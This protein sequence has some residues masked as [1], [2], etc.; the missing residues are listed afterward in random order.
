LL[1]CLSRL[2]LALTAGLSG[3]QDTTPRK[4]PSG[5]H[6]PKDELATFR[7][8]KGFRVELVASEPDVIDPVAI[9]FDENGRLFVAEM[10]GY[11]NDG[12]GEGKVSSGRIRL[13]TE[14]D[15]N[16]VYR[17]STVYA[18]GLRFPTSVMPYRGGLLVAVAPDLIYLKDNDDDGKADE[19]RVLY[20]GFGVYNIQ[21]LLNGL[22]WGLDNWVYAL[23]GNNPSTVRSPENKDMPEI[24]LRGRGIRFH[25]D[26][27]GSLDPTSGGGQFGLAT[28]DWQRWFTATNSQHLRH[29]VLPD[30]YL[31]R[32]PYLPVPAVTLDVPDGVDGHGAV[33]KV[34]RISPFEGWRVERT[35][36]RKDSPDSKRFPAT[37]LV[38]GGFI[39]SACSPVVY[40]ADLFP[41]AFLNNTFVCEPANN[42]IHR[43]ILVPKGATFAAKRAEGDSEFLASTD[44]WFRPVNLTVGPDGA[45]YVVDFYREV[46]ETPLSLPPEMKKKLPLH[47]QGKG[48]IWRIVPQGGAKFTKPELSKASA[49]D[50]VK[51]LES[52]NQWWRLTAQ[53]LLVERQDKAA[54]EPLKKLAL[55]SKSPQARAHAHWTLEGLKQLPFGH[56]YDALHDPV[57]EV[58]EQG[59][60][61]AESRMANSENMRAAVIKLA[62][63]AS[64]RVRFQAAFT[65]GATDA[66]EA[67]AALGKLLRRDASEPWTQTAALSSAGRHGP[68]LLESLAADKT[69]IE[70][71][72][73]A[74]VGLLTR[75]ASMIAAK[76]D[77]AEMARALQLLDADKHGIALWQVA[78]LEGL[79]Q[80]QQL[81]GRSL[82]A[83]WE[84]PPAALKDA[85]TR[86]T[87]FFDRAA[88]S[89][90]DAKR[91]LTQRVAAAH[92]LGFG[93]FRNTA[94]LQDLL[95]PSNPSELQRAAVRALASHDQPKVAE[96]L[97][98][99]WNSQGPEVRNDVLEAVFARPGR[100]AFLLTAIEQ[101]KVLAAQLPP[102]RVEQLRLHKD[103]ELRKRATGLLA[104]RATPERQ[105]VIE[106]YRPALDLKADPVK[107]KL[108]FQKVCSTCHRLEKVGQEVGPDLLS[109]LK[110]KTPEALLIDILDPSR[111]VDP[112][113]IN[114]IVSTKDG[115]TRTGIVA[116]EGPS[117]ITLRRANKEEEDVLRSQ[118]EEIQATT[119][120]LMPDELE[121]QFNKQDLADLIGYLRAVAG[122]K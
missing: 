55:E 8:A 1:S 116:V 25:P 109:A 2:L 45:L 95:A 26:V 22:Q 97:L 107:G 33:C 51:L 108:V 9:A 56:V 27:P 50:L 88:A 118:I 93:P 30:Q 74:Q 57:A 102:A 13:L 61:L 48:R 54:V 49:A 94:P 52:P 115:R 31:R 43:D 19:Q 99:Q 103:P 11:P 35:T 29:I 89:A 58:R 6:A 41:E 67:A 100:L 70:N 90:A 106:E 68:T 38:P 23:N 47:T 21:Q 120:S 15:A 72:T 44:I 85:V 62:N 39:T 7:V 46:I 5:P 121:K 3:A 4:P 110:T 92:L 12:V 111:E 87:P 14:P 81:G 60:R 113:Y 69:F 63:D 65:L 104:S 28:D 83:L 10:R 112:R 59:L 17:K 18:D 105:K 66:P 24:T 20:T 76:G 117:S 98:S 16:G 84:E 114:Y 73:T 78:I 53:R 122:L 101:K 91:P 119:K 42:L 86:A 40:T 77:A 36:M 80:G 79:G 32:N 64:P 71:M 82:R 34:H 75:L 96:M 37:E